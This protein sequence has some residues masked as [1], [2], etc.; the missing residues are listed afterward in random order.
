MGK[1]IDYKTIYDQ[2]NDKPAKY[3]DDLNRFAKI[4][5]WKQNDLKR[6]AEQNGE[7]GMDQN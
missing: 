1:L 2:R 6:G 7:R 4:W 3:L 5:E